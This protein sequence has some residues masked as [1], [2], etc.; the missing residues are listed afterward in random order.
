MEN[1]QKLTWLQ[2][3]FLGLCLVW[4]LCGVAAVAYQQ[5][6]EAVHRDD[7]NAVIK[8]LEHVETVMSALAVVHGETTH[9][10]WKIEERLKIENQFH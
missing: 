6:R 2:K 8:R 7:H 10:V 3:G 1:G 4:V 9:R 5:G